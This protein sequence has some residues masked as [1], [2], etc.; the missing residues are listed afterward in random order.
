[1]TGFRHRVCVKVTGGAGNML[2]DLIKRR[3]K[4]DFG[5]EGFGVGFAKIEV[6]AKFQITL[7][8]GEGATAAR[9]D[10]ACVTR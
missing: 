9:A 6:R 3:S 1:M 10:Q 8:E 4:L 7:I 2:K 5:Q